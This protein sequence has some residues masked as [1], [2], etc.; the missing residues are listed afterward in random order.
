MVPITCNEVYL[1]PFFGDLHSMTT[2]NE[3]E[4]QTLR[5]V[6]GYPRILERK[7]IGDWV[8]A[9]SEYEQVLS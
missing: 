1:R 4:G 5:R 8:S 3:D 6:R 9:I 7:H 2:C